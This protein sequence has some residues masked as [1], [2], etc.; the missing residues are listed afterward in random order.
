MRWLIALLLVG[1]CSTGGSGA[2]STSADGRVAH[3]MPEVRLRK[4]HLVRP[5]LI[6]FPLNYEV[7]C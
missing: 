7:Y 5:D 6:P 3:L 2:G 4:I 1:M